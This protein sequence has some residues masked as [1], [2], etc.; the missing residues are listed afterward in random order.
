MQALTV[1]VITYH[2][3]SHFHLSVP[4][5]V[6]GTQSPDIPEFKLMICAAEPNP[7]STMASGELSIKTNY[8]LKDLEQADIVIVP[9]WRDPKEKPPQPLLAALIQAYQRGAQIVGLCLGTYVLAATGLLDQKKASTHWEFADD[10]SRR[11][12][13]VQL[14]MSALYIEED[15]LV[16][17]AG[18]AAGL[19]CCLHLIRQR[20]GGQIANKIARRLVI[21][22]HRQG[23]QAQFIEHTVPINSQDVRLNDLL[24]WLKENLSQTHTLDSLANRVL[25]SR[26]TFTRR[27]QKATG[28]PVHKWLI[29]ERL[30]VTQLLL[31]STNHSIEHIARIAGFNTTASLRHHFQINFGVAPI[32]WR[33]MFKSTH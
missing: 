6:F 24:Q 5:I 25:M 29:N 17:S 7:V 15:R 31:E 1:A 3:F 13:S 18:T 4:C 23:G 9:C 2:Q 12:P 11:F 10:F 33:Q 28:M 20:Y 27:F 22:P 21:Q 8:D 26:R 14:D 16:T 19:D 30:H 32:Q